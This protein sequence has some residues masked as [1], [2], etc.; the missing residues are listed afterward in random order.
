M[1]KIFQSTGQTVGKYEAWRIGPV[2]LTVK[3]ISSKRKKRHRW[4]RGSDLKIEKYVADLKKDLSL[5]TER[6]QEDAK[7]KKIYT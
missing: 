5:Q 6:P 3:Y 7:R 2:V 1:E 4:R